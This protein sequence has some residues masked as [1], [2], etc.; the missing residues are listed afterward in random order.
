MT[1]QNRY[2]SVAVACVLALIILLF[3]IKVSPAHDD[4]HH[5]FDAWY[6]SLKMPDSPTV[7]C[8]GVADAYWCSF[9][10]T[11][12]DKNYCKIE[13]DRI[14]MHRTQFPVGMEIE[15]PDRKMM[16]GLKTN[17]NPTGHSVVFLSSGGAVFCFVMGS[18]I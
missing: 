16:E 7:S 18:G 9:P 5:E 8:C 11:R 13:D 1:E 4:E 3:N 14:I 6:E 10:Y 2:L 15:I 12:D 17:G